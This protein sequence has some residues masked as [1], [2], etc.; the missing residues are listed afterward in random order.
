MMSEEDEEV[1]FDRAGI[2]ISDEEHGLS[3]Q[4]SFSGFNDSPIPE[5]PIFV[6]AS[7]SG[8]QKAVKGRVFQTICLCAAFFGL[9]CNAVMLFNTPIVFIRAQISLVFRKNLR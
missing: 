5:S 8:Q 9:V 7:V 4:G 1:L 2:I 3:D 6:R